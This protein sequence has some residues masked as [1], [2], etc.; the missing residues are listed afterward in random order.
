M[1][2]QAKTAIYKEERVWFF[3]ALGILLLSI[4][5]YIY[6]LS[7]SVMHVV[8]RKELN[9]ELRHVASEISSYEAEYIRLQHEVSNDIASLQGY[10]P[11]NDKV[12]IDRTKDSLVLSS[13]N[14][15]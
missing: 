6:F 10:V 3:A 11:A 15:R 2:H 9:Q 12:F 7:A 13:R 8:I 4:V 5:F 1:K 14:E